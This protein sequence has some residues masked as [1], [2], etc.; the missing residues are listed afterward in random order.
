MPLAAIV[1]PR[2]RVPGLPT[3]VLR[4]LQGL[5]ENSGRTL[6]VAG[7][8]T[9]GKSRLLEDLEAL[10]RSQGARIVH[11]RGSYRSRSIPYGALDGLRAEDLDSSAIV[12]PMVSADGDEDRDPGETD[13]SLAVAPIPYLAERLPQGRRSRGERARTTFL[14]QPV[15]GRSANEGDP[16]AYWAE[17]MPE[18]VGPDAHAV[19]ILIDDGSLFDTESREFIVS[20]SRHATFRPFLIA[21]ALDSSV[22]GITAW[23]DAFL[24][25]G[26]VDWYRIVRG[27]P[28]ARE[29]H[30]VKAA[31]DEL[32][33]V[34]QRIVGL[35]ALLGGTV[36]EV[37]LSRVARLTHP[38]LKE[39]LLP[40]TEASVVKA[41]EGKVTLVHPAW[42]P[43]IE[44]LLPEKQRKQM[45]LEIADA[46][47]ALSP[48]P[49]LP[50]RI[51]VAHHYLAWFPGP[52]AL[53]YL[54]EAA[55][56][57][58]QLLAFDSAEELLDQAISCLAAL[59]PAERDRL[60]PE[61][62][63][64]HA[65]ALFGAGRL[66]D[67]ETEVRQGFDDAVRAKIST[68]TVAEWI[69]P[70]VLSMRVIG[71]RP[72]LMTTLMELVERCHAGQQV[73]VE[74]LLEAL[75][76]EFHYERDEP[77]RAREESHRAA[78]LARRL[79]SQHIQ[80]LALLAVGLSRTEGTPEE[81]DLAERFLRAARL[82]LARTRR[83]ELDALA[84][85]LEARLL[86]TRGDFAKAREQ[87]ERSLPAL[88]RAKLPSLEIY[89]QLGIA[90]ILLNRS[91]SR[92]LAPALERARALTE[93]LHLM[94]P[95][96]A[97]LRLWLLEARQLAVSDSVDGARERWQAIVDEPP[98][99][100]IP[101]FRSEA[102]VRLALLE[103]ASGHKDRGDELAARLEN[104]EIRS[105]LPNGWT[106]WT[107]DLE[108]LAR[109]S[110]H[111]GGP[112]PPPPSPER[113][114][115]GKVR[116]RARV[117]TVQNRQRSHGEE[118]DDH[119]PVQ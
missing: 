55:D 50:R 60:A 37:V 65:R 74:V 91:I 79:P 112:L 117:Q 20:L 116:E 6:V 19:A 92:G 119:D 90:E 111:G 3:P 114:R 33:S 78:L 61:L 36:G 12:A 24:G 105:A 73:E 97:L 113:H 98:A 47:A 34:S 40:A 38:Q 48:E 17:L 110:D 75:V 52:M 96:P 28:D 108:R 46:L 80:A 109:A 5:A 39:A 99:D 100:S 1:R 32:P 23:E 69:E 51:E 101:R 85:D 26:D 64:L 10:L 118:H 29:A 86:E 11:L 27:L 76:S 59:P 2:Y 53:R 56:I 72:S 71:P 102:M 35:V 87:R 13:P 83:W 88:Q 7:P 57:S 94:P 41:R 66:P 95:S 4:G 31:Y 16:E 103:Y 68:E 21:L 106:A 45:H 15:R 82:L 77:D 8:P 115:N 18:F 49:N 54:L 89:Q 22:A 25:R 63:F 70:L 44:D 58:L 104:P 30:R 9:S 42:G 81:Q 84:E 107:G 67:A 14:G 43:L 93:L 62:R